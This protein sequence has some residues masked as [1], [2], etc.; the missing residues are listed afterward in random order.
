MTDRLI[1]CPGESEFQVGDMIDF[2]TNQV[3]IYINADH[4]GYEEIDAIALQGVEFIE[5]TRVSED[6]GSARITLRK[7]TLVALGFGL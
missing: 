3:K 5:G 7:L 1:D 6:N 4:G 2:P